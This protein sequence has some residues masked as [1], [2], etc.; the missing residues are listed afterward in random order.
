MFDLLDRQS[1][2]IEWKKFG[3]KVD[4]ETLDF[5]TSRGFKISDNHPPRLLLFGNPLGLPKISL[6]EVTFFFLN[7]NI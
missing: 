3:V 4:C 7:L 1:S 6:L 5:G 2:V